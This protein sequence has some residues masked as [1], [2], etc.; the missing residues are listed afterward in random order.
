[1]KN[2][3][4]EMT[5]IGFLISFLIVIV[6]G[7]VVINYTA[8][9]AEDIDVV[10]TSNSSSQE[11]LSE[12]TATLTPIGSIITSSEVKA[13]NQTWLELDGD[14][15]YVEIENTANLDLTN[16][17]FM[18]KFKIDNHTFPDTNQ[19][20]VSKFGGGGF[21]LYLT[22][23]SKINF[24]TVNAT[25]V[26]VAS[27]TS[28][29]TEGEWHIFTVVYTEG[30][31]TIYK[32]GESL[33]LAGDTF[34]PNLLPG[35]NNLTL[36]ANPT[37]NQYMNGSIAWF[38]YWNKSVSPA[39]INILANEDKYP[40]SDWLIRVP[41]LMLHNVHSGTGDGSS[42]WI[43]T[44]ERLTE[45]LTWL[46]D[47]G[48]TPI[49]DANY[50]DWRNGDFDMPEKPVVLMFDDGASNVY[51]YAKP[52]FESFGWTASLG[53][54]GRRPDADPVN[55]MDWDELRELYADGWEIA[56][57][58]NNHTYFTGDSLTREEWIY[59]LTESKEKI[60]SELGVAP[61]TYV[62]PGNDYNQ[63]Y[64][65]SC[66]E[67]YDICTG[68]SSGEL[69]YKNQDISDGDIGVY[70]IA[71][72]NTTT[73]EE[74][75]YK[76]GYEDAYSINLGIN[77]NDGTNIY[78]SSNNNNIGT[79]SGAT[80]N[81][82]GVLV[83]LTNAADYTINTATGL[84]TI[85]NSGYSWAWMNTSWDY[86]TINN[87]NLPANTILHL[88]EIFIAISFI[89]LAWLFIRSKL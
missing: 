59:Q 62:F 49:T 23:S 22:S 79:I 18:V 68:K 48:Y 24:V 31:I 35:T 60:L 33:S 88:I 46:N 38:K 47:S 34:V 53:I 66:H 25:D 32:D 30:E 45:Y 41:H 78:D 8:D 1:M 19:K 54:V 72:L 51:A 6:L 14:G 64:F 44:T 75:K 2:K 29:I 40:K 82:D 86:N 69:N 85:V 4:A 74:F 61:R 56:S 20:I 37:P 9:T 7:I 80:W 43:I 50:Y 87:R 36:G 89:A 28:E 3:K 52:I 65:D 84:F 5:P 77:E 81:N 55:Y 27:K 70:R 63:S 17:S 10:T 67:Y 11:I 39:T 13:N 71:I 58:S 26:Y 42:L 76:L 57:H 16:F 73:L 83:A 15:D 12:S 21:A